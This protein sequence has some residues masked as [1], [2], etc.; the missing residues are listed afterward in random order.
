MPIN[1]AA[2]AKLRAATFTSEN[3]IETMESMVKIQEMMGASGDTSLPLDYQEP[4]MEV[5]E[6]ELIPVITIGLRAVK[7]VEILEDDE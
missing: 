5:K 4:G 6:G 7:I 1:E 3:F 2:L